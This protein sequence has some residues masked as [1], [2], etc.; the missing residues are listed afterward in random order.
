MAKYCYLDIDINDARASHKRACEFV[1]Q[2]SI[3]YGL[4]SNVLREL[5]GREKL[6][7]PDL[8]NSDFSW[9]TKGGCLVEPQPVTRMI[10]QMFTDDSPLATENFI[11]LCTGSKGISKAS[12]VKLQYEGCKMHRYVPNFMIQGGDF[13]F[14]N[15]TGGESIW[16]KKF[17]DDVKGL[18]LKHNKR[19]ILSMGNSGKNSNSSQFFVTLGASAPQCD[20]KHVVFGEMKHGFDTLDYIEE[21]LQQHGSNSNEEPGVPLVITSC[22]MWNP[23]SQQLINGYW[24][25]DDAF[26]ALPVKK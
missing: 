14:N 3:K 10:F 22:G 11:A 2:N 25:A 16:T 12:N 9:N 26:S 7:V 1:D 8:Y 24:T 19:G 4:S 18:K 21:I 15:G 17:K 20:K 5:G 23:D 6:S 13:I